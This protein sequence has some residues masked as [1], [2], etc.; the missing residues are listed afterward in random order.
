MTTIPLPPVCPWV[1]RVTLILM[2]A[3]CGGLQLQPA[4]ISSSGEKAIT[5]A[6]I[7]T[8]GARNAW[9]AL[10]R[11]T[12]LQLGQFDIGLGPPSPAGHRGSQIPPLVVVNGVLLLDGVRGLAH[13][14]AEEI[15]SMRVLTASAAA[16]RYGTA[17]GGGAIIIETRRGPARH[18]RKNDI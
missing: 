16:P 10:R 14:P 9:E 3:G 6:E 11:L 12:H 8:S 2:V 13:L 7:Q 15:A 4:A 5:A 18:V 1:A 17:A